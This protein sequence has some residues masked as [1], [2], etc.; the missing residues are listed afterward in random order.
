MN[1]PLDRGCEISTH[2]FRRWLARFAGY[3]NPVT[4]HLI[5]LWLDQ[6]SVQDQDLAARLLDSVLFVDHQHIHNCFRQLLGSLDGWHMSASKRAGRWFFVP[7][8]G[9]VGESGDSMVHAFRMATSMTKR[10]FDSLF[11]HRS[12]LIAN[13]PLAKDT[14]VLI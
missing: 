5:E 1:R 2:R 13:N 3:R 9:S 4:Q 7:F 12:E 6:F 14:V 11:I 10:K 8:S